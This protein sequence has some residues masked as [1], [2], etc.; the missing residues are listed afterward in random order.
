MA[1][2]VLIEH[3]MDGLCGVTAVAVTLRVG[4]VTFRGVGVGVDRFFLQKFSDL[5]VDFF[6]CV[7]VVYQYLL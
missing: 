6:V 2:E 3:L 4:G 7:S 5:L 1:H